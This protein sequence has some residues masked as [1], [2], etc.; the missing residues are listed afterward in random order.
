MTSQITWLYIGGFDLVNYVAPRVKYHPCQ[1]A[2]VLWGTKV[3]EQ[4]NPTAGS[5]SLYCTPTLSHLAAVNRIYASSLAC[6]PASPRIQQ[7]QFGLD[8]CRSA[9][10]V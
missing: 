1:V 10:I 5:P 9:S 3:P 8:I 6:F 2:F 7:M 4:D